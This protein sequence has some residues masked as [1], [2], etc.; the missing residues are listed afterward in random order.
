MKFLIDENLPS[1][2]CKIFESFGH[3]CTHVN[4][5]KLSNTPDEIIRDFAYE[6]DRVIVTFDLDFSRLAAKN[7]KNKPSILTFRTTKMSNYFLEQFIDRQLEEL[8]PH[9]EE[10]CVVVVDDKKLRI[11]KLP[12]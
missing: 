4:D 10:G 2:F 7:F 1:A 9:F 5:H 6:T 3:E 12:F 8:L 11:R